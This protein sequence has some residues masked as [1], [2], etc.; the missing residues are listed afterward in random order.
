MTASPATVKAGLVSEALKL[1]REDPLA[2]FRKRFTQPRTTAG[3]EFIYFNG[4]SLG[5]QPCATRAAAMAELDAWGMGSTTKESAGWHGIEARREFALLRHGEGNPGVAD[6]RLGTDQPLTQRRR[7]GQE[8]GRDAGSIEPQHR[9]QH[10]RRP[11][12][13]SPF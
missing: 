8:G 13:R 10:Q 12:R 9:L 3:G 2:P 7:R 4:N 11:R 1:D 6:L 5:L